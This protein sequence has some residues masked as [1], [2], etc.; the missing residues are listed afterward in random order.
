MSITYEPLRHHFGQKSG[1][2]VRFLDE[3]RI[4]E[5]TITPFPMNPQARIMAAKAAMSSASVNDLPDSAFAYIEPGGKK[6][7]D[8]K[9][10]PRSL[11]HFPI[12]DKAHADNAAARIAQGAEFG[13]QALPKVRA[14]QRR[15]GSN[16]SESSSL[17]FDQFSDLMAKALSITYG[18]ASK[19]AADLLVAAYQPLDDAAGTAD[20]PEPTAGAA[21]GDGT[22]DSTTGGD[23]ANYALD[24]LAAISGPHDG[25]P[26][27]EPPDTALAGPLAQLEIDRAAADMDRLEA[28]LQEGRS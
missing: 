17:D 2:Q 3:M 9:T 19:A 23:N 18:P 21:A 11:R 5:F 24:I 22:A 13:Q 28:E 16:V 6:D 10:T 7:A 14:A 12:H 15:F 25:A 27:G 8:G 26:G 20:G 1:R 4:H